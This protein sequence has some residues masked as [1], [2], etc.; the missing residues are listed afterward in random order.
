MGDREQIITIL[1]RTGIDFDAS[2]KDVLVIET[3]ESGVFVE[4][5]FGGA[6]QLEAV[7]IF[8]WGPADTAIW[9]VRGS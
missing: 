7:G 9:G 5:K 6:G 1:N 3:T 2:S 4:M 8:N